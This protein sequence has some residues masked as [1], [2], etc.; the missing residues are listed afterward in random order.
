MGGYTLLELFN[1]YPQDVAA[2]I[3]VDTRLDGDSNEAHAARMNAAFDLQFRGNANLIET[4]LAKQFTAQASAEAKNKARAI[5]QKQPVPT[6]STAL[7]A[8]THRRDH[9][10]LL[11]KIAVPTLVLVGEED[12]ITPPAI[13]LHMNMKIPNSVL[14]EI[15]APAT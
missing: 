7:F 6:L 4:S 8:M 1:K 9:T 12:A 11:S 15:P 2:A 3:F 10:E 14:L 13:A 5:I